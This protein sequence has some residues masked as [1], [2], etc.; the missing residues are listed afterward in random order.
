M[1]FFFKLP[2]L[3]FRLHAI[4]TI[5]NWLI[6]HGGK[7]FNKMRHDVIGSEL[8]LY[9]STTSRWYTVK[10]ENKQKLDLLRYGHQLGM[11]DKRYRKIG[12]SIPEIL[13]ELII[14]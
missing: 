9:N 11:F 2:N 7:V 10:I 1:D 6:I 4:T 5:D 14:F 12:F 13:S 8:V 3:I